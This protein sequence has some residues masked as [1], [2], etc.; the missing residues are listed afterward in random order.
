MKARQ[1]NTPLRRFLSWPKS[2]KNLFLRATAIV[3]L[4]LA[5]D[6]LALQTGG[7]ALTPGERQT[8]TDIFG[9]SLDA[10]KVRIA[11]SRYANMRLSVYGVSIEAR[12][13]TIVCA[14]ESYTADFSNADPYS[15]STFVHEAVHVWKAQT[16]PGLDWSDIKDSFSYR[17]LQ[18][19]PQ[20]MYLYDL[21]TGKDLL[22]YGIEQQA[23]IIADRY[24]LM[25]AGWPPLSLREE[26]T[27]SGKSIDAQFERT[28]KN[29]K[30]DP[31]YARNK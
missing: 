30:R 1:I 10:S 3:A 9:S 22:E 5:G 7:R 14:N 20:K 31:G 24:V 4:V 13:N 6:H 25:P 23:D 18:R 29:F 17:V 27:P 8:L 19:N 21:T 26:I 16:R 11:N 2:W 12:G 15:K 28:L